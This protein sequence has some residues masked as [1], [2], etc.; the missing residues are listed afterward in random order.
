MTV[1]CTIYRSGGP[2]ERGDLV[3]T[4]VEY[5]RLHEARILGWLHRSVEE[6]SG[7]RVSEE[8]D[9]RR[10]SREIALRDELLEREAMLSVWDG[11]D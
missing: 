10:K 8:A 1:T 4:L 3:R 11:D 9:R 2:I 6:G 7:R 5:R